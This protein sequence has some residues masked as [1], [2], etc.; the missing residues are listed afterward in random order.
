MATNIAET[1]ITI[2]GIVFVIG[3]M[4]KN[5]CEESLVEYKSPR[6]RFREELKNY[7]D[8]FSDVARVDGVQ[9]RS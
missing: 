3:E 9:I 5:Y 7:F 6:Y 4:Y 8:S 2:N 1:S